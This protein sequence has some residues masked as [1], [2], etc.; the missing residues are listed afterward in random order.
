MIL[1]NGGYVVS[2]NGQLWLVLAPDVRSKLMT[3]LNSLIPEMIP[4]E[5]S[6][7][8]PT[9]GFLPDFGGFRDPKTGL[10]CFVRGI[11]EEWKR[12]WRGW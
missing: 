5:V 7:C 11:P 1:A 8:N 6:W 2:K 3:R 4:I 12:A 10:H 9:P